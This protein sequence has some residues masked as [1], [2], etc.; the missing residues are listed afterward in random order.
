M[1]GLTSLFLSM[2]FVAFAMSAC[3]PS[4]SPPATPVAPTPTP[5]PPTAT[6]VPPTPTLAPPTPTPVPP[7]PTPVPPTPTPV[8]PT[9]TPVPQGEIII[10]T[11]TADS[12]PGTLRQALLD[13][14]SGDTITFDPDIFPS[15]APV[16]IYLT[17]GLPPVTQGNLTIDASNAS[18]ILDGSHVLEGWVSGLE[19]VS[20]GNTVQGVQVVNFSGAGIV[21][22]GGARNNTIGGD[23]GIGSGPMGQGNLASGNNMGIGL[24]DEGTSFNTITGNL[25]GTDA[26]GLAVRSNHGTGIYVSEGASRNMIGPD[27]IIAY[28]GEESIQIYNSNSLGNTITQNSIHD[29]GI[30]GIYL[31]DGGNAELIAPLIFDFDLH[32]GTLAG[33]A[34]AN[35]TVEIFSD[36]SD[37]GE[38]YEGQATTN[39]T[40]AFTFD[41]GASLA[42]PHLTATATDAEGNT[43]QFSAPTSGT[44]RSIVLQVGNDL[45]RTQFQTRR[46]GELENNR[47]GRQEELPHPELPEY[48][49]FTLEPDRFLTIGYKW[50][51]LEVDKYGIW[52]DV[53]WNSAEDYVDP[54]VDDAIT[55]LASNGISIIACLGAHDIDIGKHDDYG[56]FKTEDEI[57]QYLNYLRFIVRHF[58][59]RIQYYE[60]WNEEN[61]MFPDWYIDLPDY[62]NLV[63]RAVPVIREEY[64]EAKI[65]VGGTSNLRWSDAHEYLL[66]ILRSDIMPLVDVVTWHPMYGTAPDYDDYSQ[67]YYEYPSIVQEIKDVASAHGFQG[68]YIADELNWRTPSSYH[69]HE[70]W[71]HSEIVA[72][73]YYG[74]A[75]LIHLGMDVTANTI[76]WEASLVESVIQ[77]LCTVMAG[78]ESADIPIEIQSEAANIA[79]Y[80]FSLPNGDRLL[81]LW[82]DGV[83]VEEDPGVPATLTLPGLSAQKV[84]GIDVLHCFEQQ[85]ITSMEDGNVVIH[86]L[87][88]KD[89]P[90]ILRF[91]Y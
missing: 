19:I 13:A 53:D 37:E 54:Q 25:I 43:S 23:R 68:E 56:R 87:L 91:T 44:S 20:N 73:K 15:D 1:K 14:Q 70:P 6:P 74:R 88:V 28:N 75:I 59:G 62:I 52:W 27:N 46:S 61:V 77:N 50:M 34:C 49:D 31:N 71:T 21:L 58:K 40:G 36:S 65:V 80:S 85:M 8:P 86:D 45:P 81:A 10:V 18:V 47:I 30:F 2:T 60:I 69:E 7:T 41:K 17:G 11:S 26:G 83:A 4:P 66:G 64:P 3:G 24:W 57:Q 38:V 9:P 89:Y 35:C 48:S 82:T 22:S 51:R 42:G 72:A 12:G 55:V 90:I 79:S 39:G 33:T 16:T 29:N 32:A 63:H 78:T 5:A 67:Y 84:V 76:S